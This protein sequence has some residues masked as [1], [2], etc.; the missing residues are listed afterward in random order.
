MNRIS[1]HQI[2]ER[3]QDIQQKTCVLASGRIPN[4]VT[5]FAGYLVSGRMSCG[6]ISALLPIQKSQ[7]KLFVHNVFY[8]ENIKYPAGYLARYPLSSRMSRHM[9]FAGYPASVRK[10]GGRISG[11]F[12][13][14]NKPVKLL[15]QFIMCLTHKISSIRLNNW[16]DIRYPA[17]CQDTCHLLDILH[18]SVYLVAGY[19]GH[20]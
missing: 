19:P 12:L 1:G 8:T 9:S 17:G 3:I 5:S 2:Y 7:V 15:A 14:Q 11:S 10:S 13:V 6:R 20:S 18:P 16:P 4:S